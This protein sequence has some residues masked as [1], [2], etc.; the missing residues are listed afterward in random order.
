LDVATKVL[1]LPRIGVAEGLSK[2]L[3]DPASQHS[4]QKRQKKPLGSGFTG[5][6]DLITP[7]QALKAGRHF[8]VRQE[9]RALRLLFMS[10]IFCGSMLLLED[11]GAAL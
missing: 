6:L 3:I 11:A 10:A 2:V 9:C 5:R 4:L 7:R 8:P 1:S